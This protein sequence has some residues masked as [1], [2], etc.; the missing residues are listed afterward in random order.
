MTVNLDMMAKILLDDECVNLKKTVE[1]I[2]TQ[3]AD[4]SEVVDIANNMRK[5]IARLKEIIESKV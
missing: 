1:V 3:L 4:D 5:E 2:E